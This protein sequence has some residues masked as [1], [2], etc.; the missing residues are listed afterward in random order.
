MLA[1]IST[2]FSSFHKLTDD[3][4]YGTAILVR[5]SFSQSATVSST[6]PPNLS[7]CDRVPTQNGSLSLCSA[8]LRPSLTD[9]SHTA[10][11]I[12]ESYASPLSIIGM[13]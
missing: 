1:N 4:A 9:F 2:G 13:D 3:H 6:G 8:Y 12:L 11:T 7:S 10:L 5:D